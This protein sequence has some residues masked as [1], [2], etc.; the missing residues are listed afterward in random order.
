MSVL[1]KLGACLEKA[2]GFTVTDIDYSERSI[3]F[4]Y[5]EGHG[6]QTYTMVVVQN[7]DTWNPESMETRTKED[8]G[9]D[10]RDQRINAA[11]MYWEATYGWGI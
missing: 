9:N 10:G 1:T 7:G 5:S 3:N 11:S 4:D 8:A 6:T 2:E